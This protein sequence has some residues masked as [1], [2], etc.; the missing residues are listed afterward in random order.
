MPERSMVFD[1]V[2]IVAQAILLV[3]LLA[4]RTDTA[5]PPRRRGG[6]VG[7]QPRSCRYTAAPDTPWC[8]R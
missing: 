4:P 6:E 3:S 7:R 1:D 8:N 5:R 2:A